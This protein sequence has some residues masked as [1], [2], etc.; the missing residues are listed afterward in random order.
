MHDHLDLI[1]TLT[2]GLAAALA[3][4]YVTHRLG[5]SPIVGY[6]LAGVV[7]GPNTPGFVANRELAEQLAEVGVV[8]LMFGVGLHFQ[9]KEL[10]AVRRIA[11]PGAVGQSL[12]ATALG[13]LTAWAFGWGWAAGLV[14]GL[15]ISVASTVVL[16]R[17]LSDNNDLH[18]PAGHVAVGWLVVEDL[19]TVLVLVVLP[20]L[21]G[22]GTAGPGRLPLTLGLAALKI[23]A[24]VTLV[25]LLGGRLIPWLLGRVAATRSRELF[26]LTILVV[27]LGIAVGSA[28]LFGVSMAL[29]AFLAGM[30][31]GRSEF[32]LRAASEALPLR[33]AF[34]VLFF[35]SVG[36]LFNPRDLTEAPGVAAAALGIIL[37][38]KPLAALGI[39][40]LLRYPARVAVAV[41][42]ALAQIGEFSFILG[43]LGKELGLLTDR[44]LNTLVVAA[45]L[46]ISLNPLLYRLVGPIEAWASRRPRLRRWLAVPPH[47]RTAPATTPSAGGT[48][49]PRPPPRAMVVGGDGILRPIPSGW[50]PSPSHRAVVVGYG[51]VGRTLTRLLL[52]NGIQPTVIELNLGT[53]RRLREE[54]IAAVYGDASHRETLKE[55]GVDRAA[56]LILSAA[57]VRGGEEVIRLARELNPHVQVFARAAYVRELPALREAGAERAFSGEGEV[58][59]ALTEALLRGLGATPEQIDR[60]RERVH[61]DLIGRPASAEVD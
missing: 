33:D 34:A 19:F 26:T 41:A 43:A 20:A 23:G 7:V 6:L 27:A 4:G 2:G 30:V 21:F 50:Q 28:L 55:A 61:A 14:F 18:T 16:V 39:V 15:A 59:L 3:L 25:F 51:P 49:P 31:V 57:G 12:V 60:E 38:G 40:L 32:S 48:N 56:N 13:V 1:L 11:V 22:A 45:I 5:L 29:G 46:S 8:L 24:L 53:V 35:V 9:L 37:L 36:M 52:E 10:L 44:A 47:P 42:V 58:A 54:G 17:V